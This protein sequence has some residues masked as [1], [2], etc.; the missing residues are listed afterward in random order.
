MPKPRIARSVG[1]PSS[2]LA[3]WLFLLLLVGSPLVLLIA[4]AFNTGDPTALPPE[5]FG[6]S[7][8]GGVFDHLDWVRNSVIFAGSVSLLATTMGLTLAWIIARTDL[9]A[10]SWL[11]LLIILPYPMGAMVAVVAWSALGAEQNGLINDGL[12]LILGRDITPVNVYGLGGV[13]FVEA[14]IQTP[15]AF[16]L[17]EAAARGMDSS[18]EESSTVLGAGNV[19]TARRITVPLMLPSIVGSALFIFV[20]T[21][22]AFAV[23]S[24]L[25]SDIDFRVATQ[26]VYMLFNSF[27]P[28]YPLAAAL[29]LFLVAISLIVVLIVSQFLRRRSFSVIGGKGRPPSLVKLGRWK[30]V[31]GLV[32]YGYIFVAVVLPLGALVYSSFQENNRLSLA[33]SSFNLTNYQYVLFDYP[34]TSQSIVNSLGLGVVTGVVGVLLALWIALTVERSRR[35]GKGGRA[36]EQV[37]MAPQAV[38]HLIVGLALVVLMLVLPFRLYGTLLALLIAYVVIFLPLAYRGVAGVVSQ[39]DDSLSDAARVLGASP[40]RA[41]RTIVVPLMRPALVATG[42]LLFILC[43]TEVSASVMLSST[44]NRVLGPTMFNFYDSGGITLVS[45]LAMVQVVIVGVSVAFIRKLSG[46]WVAI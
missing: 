30:P 21:L 45:A 11:T 39:T 1:L 46:R 32:V 18:L 8:V 44:H 34:P 6:F 26:A 7:K 19:K 36:L 3:L 15:L 14:L 12:S 33:N 24:I 35:A 31:A 40:F 16:L 28:N 37:A 9:R 13:I 25:G 42:T 43:L 29:G 22:G 41:T 5:E 38:P 27:T 10:K 2:R 17:I 23:P 4:I 20:S